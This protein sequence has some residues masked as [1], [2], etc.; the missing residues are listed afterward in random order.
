MSTI[1]RAERERDWERESSSHGGGRSYTTVKRYKIPDHSLEEDVYE[2]EMRLV[3]RA[4]EPVEERREVREYVVERDDPRDHEIREYRY[5]R[6]VERSP[7]PARREIREYRIEREVERSTSPPARTEYRL[8]RQYERERELPR[9]SP[10][11]ELERYSRSTEYFRPEQPAPQPV[12]IRNEIRP[13]QSAPQP[14]YIRNEAPQ[15]II[16]QESA[17]QQIIIRHEEPAYDERT[18]VTQDRQVARREPRRDEED[19]Y[20]ERKVKEID[21]GGRWEDDYYDEREYGRGRYRER[22]AYSD[23][24][25][26]YIHKE[27]DTWGRDASPNH[28]RHLA[29]G[30]IAG[31]GAAELIRHH[32]GKEGEAKGHRVRQAVGYGALGAVGAEVLSRVRNRSRSSS[33]ERDPRGRRHHRS[34]SS[35]RVK[36]IG[37]L[38]AVAGIGALAYAA[39]RKNNA[40]TPVIE[41]RRSRSRHRKSSVSRASSGSRGRSASRPASGSAHNPE[42]RNRKAAQV[43]L[44]S[45]AVAG[46]VERHRSKSRNRKGERSHSRIRQGIPIAA[47]GVAGAAVT[48]LYEKQMAKKEMKGDEKE[49][50]KGRSKSRGKG[51]SKSRSK[52]VRSSG[53]RESTADDTG[54]VEYG[55]DPIYSDAGHSRRSRDYDDPADHRN[56]RRSSS[57]S[58]G[59]R[60]RRRHSRSSRSRSKSRTR[61]T[62]ETAAVAGV[63]GLAAHEAAKRRD[64]KKAEKQR[65][66]EYYMD[67]I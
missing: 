44:A 66:R 65:R 40:K 7:S 33:Y 26:V 11:G 14:I 52:S 49:K 67:A 62:A 18:E 58:S 37:T 30:V 45:A 42:H 57:S 38:A 3:H 20:Y 19:Y 32:R 48:G 22:D 55:G 54:L 10:Y 9:E 13:E 31:L 60:R 39:G 24:D 36:K 27:K 59:G 47:A 8:E 51:R 35:S 6:D 34:R 4:R 50:D 23:D 15:P 53:R 41:D 63:A 1:Y 16:I 25:V 17:P 64:R 29:E 56:R 2:S 5:E 21:R 61:Q 12:Y 43:G 28:K 46:L